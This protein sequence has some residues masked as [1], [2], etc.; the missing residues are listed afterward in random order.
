MD[1]ATTPQTP[2]SDLHLVLKRA[3]EAYLLTQTEIAKAIGASRSHVSRVER[4]VVSPTMA[5]ITAWAV[6]C[7][8]D[9][10]EVVRLGSR[11]QEGGSPASAP[12]AIVE[13]PQ[14]PVQ[15]TPGPEQDSA[16][17]APV[18]A[19][20]LRALLEQLGFPADVGGAL[21]SLGLMDS[22]L[23]AE[24]FMIMDTGCTRLPCDS[25]HLNSRVNMA[26]DALRNA[27]NSVPPELAPQ[28]PPTN[29]TGDV[30]Q[31][32]ID[33]EAPGPIRDL[34]IARR[35]QGIAK[36]GRPLG[37]ENGRDHTADAI[38]EALDG[39]AYSTAAGRVMAKQSFRDAL[40]FL[41]GEI[42][43][44]QW[45]RRSEAL[46]WVKELEEGRAALVRRA[47]SAEAQ[48]AELRADHIA[49]S[50]AVQGRAIA[51]GAPE[52][53]CKAWYSGRDAVRQHVEHKERE[54]AKWQANAERSER[55]A[56][57]LN[58]LLHLAHTELT[59][60]GVDTDGPPAARI[61][62]LVVIANRQADAD[63]ETI[64]DIAESLGLPPDTDGVE[65]VRAV[66]E[67]VLA[68]HNAG[69]EIGL[70][71]RVVARQTD[72]LRLLASSEDP[73]FRIAVELAADNVDM[74]VA[75]SRG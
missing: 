32:L 28:P 41:T 30:W 5:E 35:E 69:V 34:M 19:R 63:A 67:L 7:G 74:V 38:Q 3:R 56:A 51:E 36:Y 61:R 29:S 54:R 20:Q 75:V 64:A 27:R 25:L 40:G 71:R 4:G 6:H 33:A 9:P 60:A 46:S 26:L 59:E 1:S 18:D 8:C 43:E 73:T 57:E 47:E 39:T 42:S 13:E 48:L 52:H 58:K 44:G 53:E 2:P 31:E 17:A 11:R 55:E 49:F 10:T 23:R 22:D 15:A 66:E 21:H 65:I 24:G 37:R 12:E 70:V 14:A 68:R 45:V 72:A 62:R 50:L 16:F